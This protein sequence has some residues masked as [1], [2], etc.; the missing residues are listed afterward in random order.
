MV[1]R[2]SRALS[3]GKYLYTLGLYGIW[4][5][6]H[7]Y[8][9]T[10][11]RLMT[12]KGVV[13]RTETSI[14]LN[15]IEEVAF[16]RRGLGAYCQIVVMAHGRRRSVLVGP[17]LAKDARR[18]T[19][20]S[21]PGPNRLAVARHRL[22][23]IWAADCTLGETGLFGHSACALVRARPV[24]EPSLFEPSLFRTWPV[25]KPG[26]VPRPTGRPGPVALLETEAERYFPNWPPTCRTFGACA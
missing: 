11:D 26:P 12:G 6:R 18:L 5:K 8:V 10:D 16:A 17:L 22:V 2:P 9:L 21:R 23:M 4:R 20:K 3:L 19:G 14:P 13:N 24:F 15:R 7:I 25:S 1:V